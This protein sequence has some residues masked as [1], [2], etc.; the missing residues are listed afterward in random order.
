MPFATFSS[1]SF[2]RWKRS[3]SLSSC[4]TVFLRK[5]DRN[6]SGNLYSQRVMAFS[7]R[8]LQNKTDGRGESLPVGLF[9]LQIF[10]PRR[11]QRIELR[12][13]VVVGFT[14]LRPDPSALL[15]AVEGGIERS[16]I[17]LEYLSR[18]LADA[19]GDAPAVHGFK[20]K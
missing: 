18:H 5:S 11:G 2:S 9:S 13:A 19:L 14:P 8:G 6:R 1:I 17:H 7:S 15:Q 4:S 16:L 3:S 10:A 12:A 20:R